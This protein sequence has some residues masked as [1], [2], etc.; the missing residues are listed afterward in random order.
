MKRIL[1]FTLLVIGAVCFGCKDDKA[2]PQVPPTD[3]TTYLDIAP[4]WSVY[5]CGQDSVRA[6]LKDADV[7]EHD[8]LLW[9]TSH[10][11]KV[12]TC[13]KNTPGGRFTTDYCFNYDTLIYITATSPLYNS[14]KEAFTH[15]MAISND[16][17]SLIR[18][19]RTLFPFGAN[20]YGSTT[21]GAYDDSKEFQGNKNSRRDYLNHAMAEV[22]NF[23]PVQDPNFIFHFS[24]TLAPLEYDPIIGIPAGAPESIRKRINMQLGR[25]PDGKVGLY[26]NISSQH[27]YYIEGLL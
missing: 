8:S 27:T 1:S 12:F 7:W 21:C 6:S 13:Y 24:E 11:I 15:Y 20:F 17:N 5:F 26:F 19:D 16:L 14:P 25:Y 3:A 10:S 18:D 9:N 22:N 2:P 4:M 23:V